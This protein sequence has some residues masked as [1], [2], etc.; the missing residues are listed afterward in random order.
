[1]SNLKKQR[2][3]RPAVAYRALTIATLVAGGTFQLIAPALAAGGLDITNKA[4]ATYNDGSAA[5]IASP[6]NA[7]SN[8]VTIRVNEVTGLTIAPA[9]PSTIAPQ[10]NST[11][12]VDYT[13][14]NTGYDATQVYI[15]NTATL[16][17]TTNY[18][19]NGPLQ[20][21]SING[22][23]QAV[24]IPTT[25]T[26]AA[27]GSLTFAGGTT[28]SLLPNST[29]VVRVPVKVL[30]SATPATPL[31]I[32][33]GDT[34]TAS[35]SGA[36]QNNVVEA[37][38]PGT[39][40]VY[41]VDNLDGTLGEYPGTPVD[42]KEVMATSATITPAARLQAFAA[43]L[44]AGGYNNNSTPNLLTDDILT[45]NLALRVD[46]PAS[47]PAGLAP[48]DLYG[49]AISVDSASVNAVLVSDAIP[50]NTQLKSV[51]AAP[52]NWEIVYTT[53]GTGTTAQAATWSTT[54]P[55]ALSTVTRVGFIYRT[56]ATSPGHGPIA[57]SATTPISGFS[58]AVTPQA[59]FTG[60]QIANIAQVFGQSQPGTPVANTPT[61]IV[62]DESGDQSYNNALGGTNPV[63]LSDAAGGINSGVANPTTDGIDPS[64]GGT[65]TDPTSPLTNT[66]VDATT[67]D[68]LG[69]EDTVF[70][71]AAAPLTGPQGSPA[72]YGPGGAAGD[73]N[74][75]K[76]YTNQSIVLTSGLDPT[77]ALSN[78]QTPSLT[79]S[80]TVQN[81]STASQTITLV[82]SLPATFGP[83]EAA[84]PSGST[85]TIDPDGPTG[86]ATAVVFTY[87]GT[88]FT[89]PTGVNAPT[90][91]VNAVSTQ[92]YTV[93]IDPPSGAQL[94]GYPVI[95]NAFVD[96][97]SNSVL[98]ASEPSNQTIDSYYTGYVKLLKEAQVQDTSGNTVY[99]AFTTD[100][101]LLGAA[102]QPSRVVR[103]RIT[104]TNVSAGNTA[105]DPAG[106]KA[107]SA[108]ALTIHEDGATLPN[109]WFS[110]TVDTAAPVASGNGSLVAPSGS[111]VTVTKATNGTVTNDV[112]VYDVNVGN[113]APA[114][115]GAVTFDRQI[116]L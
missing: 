8:T 18:Q 1:M 58:F 72:I 55:T 76:D 23:A 103:Y 68:L 56:D 39:K 75:V 66:G 107:L 106:N 115:T 112:Q 99:Q 65:V 96:G 14:T 32:S 59:G 57:K 104:Y 4:T 7:T 26:G 53:S 88:A 70:T 27:T 85:V 97:N 6:F 10:P 36:P 3:G 63:P 21:V 113:I 95:V 100:S 54:A 38:T 42:Q 41:T 52:T 90:V 81:N 64:S 86:S 77:T 78:T 24:N 80:N 40:D 47:P 82:P 15:P 74:K 34:P 109:T 71:I 19:L 91:S 110:S 69:G 25:G 16:S 44:K 12:Y 49:T 62:Y 20:I 83:N 13:I 51:A 92:D 35:T 37:A 61:Q 114:G 116:K 22:I 5:S 87:N 108:N 94:T 84:L 67:G 50:A 29:V 89:L 33:L 11:L 73:P 102:A 111:A 98:D 79:F 48:S 46:N 60:G 93:A 101:A 9:A 30:G 2:N 31:T 17:D 28:G 43:V 45:Y 105:T